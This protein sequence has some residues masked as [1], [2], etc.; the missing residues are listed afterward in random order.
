MTEHKCTFILFRYNTSNSNLI[1]IRLDIS[2]LGTERN[3]NIKSN[4]N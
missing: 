2:V 3:G 4:F 1:K